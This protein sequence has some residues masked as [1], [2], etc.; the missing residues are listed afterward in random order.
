MLSYSVVAVVNVSAA[1]VSHFA[2][3]FDVAARKHMMLVII[4]MIAAVVKAVMISVLNDVDS[5][6]I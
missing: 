2:V 6:Y 1:E 4:V 5:I 3:A